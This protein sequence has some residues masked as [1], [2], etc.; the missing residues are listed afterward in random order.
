MVSCQ[1]SVIEIF[2][3]QLLVNILSHFVMSLAFGPWLGSY[4]GLQMQIQNEY[5]KIISST[6]KFIS[7]T[8]V[9]LYELV[10]KSSVRCILW[11]NF[12]F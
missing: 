5:F 8:N 1:M 10:M 9:L 3:N 7:D 4:I 12:S 2:Y 6:A 11:K